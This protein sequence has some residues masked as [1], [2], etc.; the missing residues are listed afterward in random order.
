MTWRG[1]LYMGWAWRL[2]A[3]LDLLVGG[4]GMRR[5]RPENRLPAEGDTI[6]SFRVERVEPGR[7]LRLRAD[8]KLPGA[9][10]LQFEA[11]PVTKELARLVEVVFHAPRGAFG[12]L[13][14][15]TLYPMHRLIFAGLLR[16]L[17]DAAELDDAPGSM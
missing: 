6:D 2:R 11:R 16:R 3:L 14:W 5:G 9:G 15:Y 4:V 17:A 8:M 13:Y 7:L 12:L 1:W 10:W